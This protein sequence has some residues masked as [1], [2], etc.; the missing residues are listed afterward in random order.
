MLQG[1]VE[2]FDDGDLDTLEAL[3]LPVAF[4]SAR[5]SGWVVGN[6]VSGL[7]A[8]SQQQEQAEQQLEDE[9][10]A[11]YAAELL[12]LVN[13]ESE[14]QQGYDEGTGYYYY[15][16]E[17]TQVISQCTMHKITWAIGAA[18]PVS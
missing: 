5:A 18:I 7:V 16:R 2:E 10:F 9:S 3:G 14:W 12:A 11:S 8:E 1:E 13:P 15:Y 17:S 4:G 6:G